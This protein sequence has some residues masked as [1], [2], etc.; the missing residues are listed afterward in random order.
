VVLRQRFASFDGVEL[1]T[2]L[3]S[4]GPVEAKPTVAAVPGAAR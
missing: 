1:Q 2:T 4:Q 3:T